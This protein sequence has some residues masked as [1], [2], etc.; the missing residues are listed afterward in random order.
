MYNRPLKIPNFFE[1]DLALMEGLA[2]PNNKLTVSAMEF[3]ACV[4]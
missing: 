3:N 1:F 2:Q 4:G